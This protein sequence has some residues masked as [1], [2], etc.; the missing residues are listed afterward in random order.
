MSRWEEQFR[1]HPYRQSWNR[2][3]EALG[4]AKIDDVSITTSVSELA[5]LKKVV[6]YIDGILESL[7]PELLPASTFDNFNAQASACVDQI[8]NYNSNRNIGHVRNANEHADNLLTYIRPYMVV[9]GKLG[10]ALQ[11]AATDYIKTFETGSAEYSETISEL[12]ADA[13]SKL[14]EMQGFQAESR[15]IKD[16]LFAAKEEFVGR[17]GDSGLYADLKE[18]ISAINTSHEEIQQFHDEIFEGD[19]ENVAK[20]A[21]IDEAVENSVVQS[22]R[23]KDVVAGTE[24]AHTKII[25]FEKKILGSS[26]DGSEEGCFSYELDQ[27]KNRLDAFE[28]DQAART[29][30]LNEQIENLLPGATSAGLASAYRE[31]KESFEAPINNASKVFYWSIGVLIVGS[32][33]LCLDRISW[34]QGLVIEW[35]HLT[36][37]QSVLRSIAYKLP[38]YGPAIWLTYYA[39]KRRSE[40]QRLK[41][42][43]AHKEALAK[44]YD[45]FRKQIDALGA[46]DDQLMKAL[47]DRAINAIAYNASQTLDGKHGDKM[48]FHEAVEKI[49]QKV[50]EVKTPPSS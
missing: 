43:Y 5:R 35:T 10:R 9:D 40:Y 48:P 2:L 24:S 17:D 30:A 4:L 3:Q 28:R 45:S 1:V 18:K 36:D 34:S 8:L 33:L 11:R 31:M 16:E 22:K 47:L 50:A 41:Q 29:K 44:S 7:D 32:V 27:Q 39:S 49:V 14:Q 15:V 21:A 46:G 13:S 42:E 6:G 37:W 23:A 12:A 20:K 26:S 25:E 38:F 19:S